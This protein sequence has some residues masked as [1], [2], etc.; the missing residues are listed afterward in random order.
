MRRWFAIGEVDSGQADV[1]NGPAM[2]A[3]A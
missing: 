1:L 3:A 2:A